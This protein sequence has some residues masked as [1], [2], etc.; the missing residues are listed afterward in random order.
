MK[1]K[2][3]CI[4]AYATL[5]I[6]WPAWSHSPPLTGPPANY[7]PYTEPQPPHADLY[8]PRSLNAISRQLP[9]FNMTGPGY[10]C[11]PEAIPPIYRFPLQYYREVGYREPDWVNSRIYDD[12]GK[13][14]NFGRYNW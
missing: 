14:I 8:K 7:I 9:E 5:A 13:P 10:I 4:L 11:T 1:T 3:I 6:P 2:L 12:R